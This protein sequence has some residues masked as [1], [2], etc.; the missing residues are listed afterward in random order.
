LSF[1]KFKLGVGPH[2]LGVA[3]DKGGGE[4]QRN[5]VGILT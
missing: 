3:L 4:V 5:L 2:S 1:G